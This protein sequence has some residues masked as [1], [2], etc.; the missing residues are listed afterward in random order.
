M[1]RRGRRRYRPIQGISLV[2]NHPGDEETR[3]GFI[4]RKTSAFCSI[5]TCQSGQTAGEP[6]MTGD[7]NG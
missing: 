3:G 1:L 4:L 5:Q 6:V 7:H 2:W